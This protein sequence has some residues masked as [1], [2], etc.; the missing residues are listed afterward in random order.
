MEWTAVTT[1]LVI[2]LLQVVTA[3][4]SDQEDAQGNVAH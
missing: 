2:L 1:V 4:V 3:S